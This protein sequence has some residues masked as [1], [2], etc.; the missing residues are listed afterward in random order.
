MSVLYYL[1]AGTVAIAGALATIA[2]WAPRPTRIRVL[3]LAITVMFID[4][5]P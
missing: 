3:A 4:F 1:F 2:I 5:P